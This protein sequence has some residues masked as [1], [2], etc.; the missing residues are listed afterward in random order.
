MRLPCAV[1]PL[2]LGLTTTLA[3]QAAS[4]AGLAAAR[5]GIE[6]GSVQ[7][8]AAFQRADAGALAQVYDPQGARLNEGG[9]VIRGRQAITD[10]VRKFLVRSGPVRV[11]IETA[12]VWLVDPD[13]GVP[14]T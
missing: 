7:Y 14:G 4:P 13:M 9:A 6:A 1:L 5:R 11:G 3:G 10:D 2:L 12:A 8:K